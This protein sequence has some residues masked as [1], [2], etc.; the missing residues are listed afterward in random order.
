MKKKILLTLTVLTVVVVLSTL[1]C[2]AAEFRAYDGASPTVEGIPQSAD[3]EYLLSVFAL[4]QDVG[5]IS[6]K[7][8]PAV[9]TFS[10]SYLQ[11]FCVEDYSTLTVTR[12]TNV[13]TV[14]S[15]A[16]VRRYRW[17]DSVGW[18]YN[19]ALSS[20]SYYSDKI[21]FSAVQVDGTGDYVSFVGKNENANFGAGGNACVDVYNYYTS[22]VDSFLNLEQKLDD[23]YNEGLADGQGEGY[24]VG[25][26]QGYNVGY[27]AGYEYGDSHGYGMGYDV[28]Y[29]EGYDD[30]CDEGK[31]LGYSSG[32]YDC[33]LTHSAIR[34]EAAA[35]AR[36]EGFNAG[37]DAGIEYCQESHQTMLF[38]EFQRGYTEGAKTST[39]TAYNNGYVTGY[40]DCYNN[41]NIDMESFYDAGKVDGIEIGYT[42]AIN[43]GNILKQFVN[44]IFSAPIDGIKTVLDIEIFGINF[45]AVFCAILGFSI[46]G[47]VAFIIL[48]FKR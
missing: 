30:G 17:N 38:D 18:L 11:L 19:T 48:K 21:Y 37:R 26:E 42:N 47:T 3:V 36:E 15:T 40:S 25:Y 16:I 13:G 46:T 41:L 33:A 34:E 4:Q 27:D 7:W 20:F 32:K 29:D 44:G 39:E 12:G 24:T 1:T 6:A 8:R 2:Y 35:K 9:L 23:K 31:R 43:D 45:F 5:I 14:A 28:G 22:I 10:D